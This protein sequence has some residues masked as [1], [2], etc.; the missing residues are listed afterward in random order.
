MSTKL[1]L[2]LVCLIPT[3]VPCNKITILHS[4][5]RKKIWSTLV[6]WCFVE[7]RF[8]TAKKRGS[9]QRKLPPSP[10]LHKRIHTHKVKHILSL[11]TSLFWRDWEVVWEQLKGKQF[12]TPLFP[13][14]L[15]LAFLCRKLGQ[16]PNISCTTHPHKDFS[17]QRSVT[18]WCEMLQANVE[19]SCLHRP[20]NW[21]VR[22]LFDLRGKADT[23]SRI[24]QT[25]RK[26]YS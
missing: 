4:I 18:C 25:E 17:M 21:L 8:S 24:Y 14:I 5:C 20:E 10:T 16:W 22:Q 12:K 15:G 1:S 2:I 6:N 13:K 7:M 3:Q 26:G 11:D 19:G 23:Q 9:N